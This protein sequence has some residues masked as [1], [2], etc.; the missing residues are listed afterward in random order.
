MWSILLTLVLT[1]FASTADASWAPCYNY[2]WVP[3]GVDGHHDW[4]GTARIYHADPS[5]WSS[6]AARFQLFYQDTAGHCG[7]LANE[8]AFVNYPVPSNWSCSPFKDGNT[9]SFYC[10]NSNQWYT[11]PVTHPARPY[12]GG[13]QA[14]GSDKID[15]EYGDIMPSWGLA[16][17]GPVY[18]SFSP[19]LDP[20][21]KHLRCRYDFA[22][23][24]MYDR[25]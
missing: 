21:V 24:F 25:W 17:R 2:V 9:Y 23:A 7:Y 4:T 14:N 3:M 13:N 18:A 12:W 20:N 8:S 6:T 10:F 22:E 15:F 16:D 11:C 19:T 1:L 5:P